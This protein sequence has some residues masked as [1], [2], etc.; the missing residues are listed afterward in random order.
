MSSYES[1]RIF[2]LDFMRAAIGIS[3][4]AQK[5]SLQANSTRISHHTYRHLQQNSNAYHRQERTTYPLSGS[6]PTAQCPSA[7]L[8][9]AASGRHP[10]HFFNRNL[11]DCLVLDR[12]VTVFL[13]P[14]KRRVCRDQDIVLLGIADHFGLRQPGVY[15]HLVAGKGNVV[16]VGYQ[17]SRSA[18]EQLEMP[19]ARA[20]PFLTRL[21]IAFHVGMNL[22]D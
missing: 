20:L 21:C 5:L 12:C 10:Y 19:I 13:L 15:L 8:N 11:P 7:L 9:S 17:V 3:Q 18:M 14:C 6:C 16:C 4:I 1:F 2:R 22:P